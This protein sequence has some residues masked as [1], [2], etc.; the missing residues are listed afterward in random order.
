MHLN[1]AQRN[2]SPL[3]AR[4]VAHLAAA[5]ICAQL[6]AEQAAEQDA[7]RQQQVLKEAQRLRG[8]SAEL[9]ALQSTIKTAQ[10]SR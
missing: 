9:R 1:D 8:Q 5:R 2:S 10:A 4:Q 3:Q 7:H 6:E